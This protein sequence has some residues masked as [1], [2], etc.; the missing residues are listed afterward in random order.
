MLNSHDAEVYQQ[1]NQAECEMTDMIPGLNANL[2]ACHCRFPRSHRVFRRSML[3]NYRHYG[4][5]M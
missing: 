4:R 1:S 3:L 2:D 5:G